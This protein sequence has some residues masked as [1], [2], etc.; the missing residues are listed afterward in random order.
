MV[1]VKSLKGSNDRN[2]I[3]PDELSQEIRKLRTCYEARG[4]TVGDD[5][6]LFIGQ[7]SHEKPISRQHGC[8]LIKQI[9]EKAKLMGRVAFHS[10]RKTFTTKIFKLCKYNLPQVA[11]YTGHKSLNSLQAYIETCQETNLTRQL[12]WI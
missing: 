3:L 5:T 6:Y 11:V 12:G 7:K 10:F 1:K 4:L 2:L 8:Y 9:K